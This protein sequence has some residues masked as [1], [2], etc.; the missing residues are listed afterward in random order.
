VIKRINRL[1]LAGD[2]EYIRRTGKTY[3]NPLLILITAP[4][5]FGCPRVGI[6]VGKRIGKAFL[7]NLVKR[8]LRAGMANF[9][10]H[11]QGGWDIMLIARKPSSAASFQELQE[12]LQNL[13]QR[14][15][16]FVTR[17]RQE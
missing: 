5:N 17:S 6:A 8:R 13:L 7:R 9:L 16:F 2:F 4:N 11:I 1:K 14:T 10:P 3:R 15:S 12:A